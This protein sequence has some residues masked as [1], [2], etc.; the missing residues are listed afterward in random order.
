MLTKMLTKE[1]RYFLLAV[2]FFSR[3]PVPQHADFDEAE[4]NYAAKY[5]PLVGIMV[6]LCGA[7]AFECAAAFLPQTIAIL[8]SMA[9]TI[10]ITGAFHE[11]GLADSADGLGG[12][13]NREQ[14]LT[15]M[16]DSRLGTYGAVALFFALFTKFYLLQAMHSA[17]IPFALIVAHTVSRLCAV[18]LMATLTYAK[19]AGKA[20]PLATSLSLSSLC[21]AN[22]LG[23]LPVLF[24]GYFLNQVY[25]VS[26]LMQL[27][28]MIVMPVFIGWYW[29]R[30]KIQH[31]LAGYTG[32][33]LGAVQQITELMIYFGI[34]LWSVN[35]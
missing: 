14:I 11:D 29:W 2:G 18:W 27:S 1:W 20:K 4:L 23:L 13:W 26:Q 8:I 7:G 25:S 16:V 12:G 35:N 34:V 22:V 5:F 17:W 32:D 3:I 9:T 30:H 33:T 15:I 28:L 6:G 21:L 31:W 19:T 10:Y 24:M